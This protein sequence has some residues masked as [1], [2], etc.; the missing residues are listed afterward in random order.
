MRPLS[1]DPLRQ[2]LAGSDG[3]HPVR[4]VFGYSSIALAFD[5]GWRSGSYDRGVEY[6]YAGIDATRPF[7]Y[8]MVADVTVSHGADTRSASMG[9]RS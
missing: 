3:S 8:T 1:D 6:G 5:L 2:A 7:A 4:I 9:S